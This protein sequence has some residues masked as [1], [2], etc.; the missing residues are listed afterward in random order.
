[1][2]RRAQ[3]ALMI[4]ALGCW[5]SA[6]TSHAQEPASAY[7]F[8]LSKELLHDLLDQKS[9]LYTVEVDLNGR[10]GMHPLGPSSSDDCEMH[11]AGRPTANNLMSPDGV[12]VEPPFICENNPPSGSSW[13]TYFQGNALSDG[14]I[15]KATGFPRLLDE[16]LTGNESDSNPHHFFELHPLTR[17][18]CG[19]EVT[20]FVPFM[21]YH[22]GA[23]EITAGSAAKCFS[24]ET[25][26]RYRE[27]KINNKKVP[28]YEFKVSR[29]PNCGNYLSF[30]MSVFSEWIRAVDSSDPNEAKGHSALARVKPTGSTDFKTIKVYT[31]PGNS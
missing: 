20:E 14:T 13:P 7:D 12:V 1:M 25:E 21:K 31:L 5:A 23:G 26:V 15:C 11:L 18:E 27:T 29:P 28:R 22:D 2:S 6:P 24:I 9:V 16:H 3:V 19:A 10:S 17:L 4:I 8:W 30:E